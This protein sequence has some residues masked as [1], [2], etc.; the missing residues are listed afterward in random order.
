MLLLKNIYCNN[1][2]RTAET[3]K[4]RNTKAKE[5]SLFSLNVTVPNKSLVSD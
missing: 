4:P 5:S 3:I 1:T 2:S